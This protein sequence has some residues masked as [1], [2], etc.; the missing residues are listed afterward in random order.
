M[1]NSQYEWIELFLYFN[2]KIVHAEKAISNAIF[3]FELMIN[4]FEK[5]VAI[6]YPISRKF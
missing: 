5:S 4:E 1:I 6:S 3:D 2:G